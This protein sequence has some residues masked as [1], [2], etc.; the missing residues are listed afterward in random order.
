VD[1]QTASPTNNIKPSLES[2]ITPNSRTYR[3]RKRRTK[4]ADSTANK[5]QRGL[6]GTAPIS[7]RRSILTPISENIS[8]L[9]LK[10]HS[11][12]IRNNRRDRCKWSLIL[13]A[14]HLGI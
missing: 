4:T 9:V 8:G 13:K 3:D 1:L 10:N 2:P 5:I 14:M 7:H 6:E 12:E 11:K